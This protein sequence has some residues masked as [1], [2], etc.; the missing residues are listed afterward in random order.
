MIVR[1]GE[2]NVKLPFQITARLNPGDIVEWL[3]L[4]LEPKVVYH[5]VIGG[6]EQKIPHEFYNGRTSV[7]N[8]QQT[9]LS[10]T[11]GAP[12][13]GTYTCTVRRGGRVLFQKKV[14]VQG[15]YTDGCTVVVGL[16]GTL[17]P[18]QEGSGFSSVLVVLHSE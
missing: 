18:Q 7:E 13:R 2:L 14:V 6:N 3:C 5:H 16:V 17:L 10:L 8:L 1:E 4:G 15:E 11:I 12:R 9:D